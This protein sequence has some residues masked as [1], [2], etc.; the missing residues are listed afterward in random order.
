[1]EP[2]DA[3]GEDGVDGGG[4]LLWIDGDDGPGFGALDEEAAGVGG[5]EGFFEVHGG[6]EGVWLPAGEV[7]REGALKDAEET[8]AGGFSGGGGAAVFHGV[9]SAVELKRLG[10][11]LAE[12]E[13]GEAEGFLAWRGG[14]DATDQIAVV[15]PEVEGAA[16]VVCG[17]RVFGV[18]EIKEGL[19]IFKDYGGGVGGKIVL[20]DGGDLCRGLGGRCGLWRHLNCYQPR[21]AVRWVMWARWWREC[22]A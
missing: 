21:A 5:A 15:V 13:G 20:K 7:A 8:G 4:G 14:E 3:K 17:E 22:Q 19:A 11:G 6:A 1:M 2:E 18:L 9:E 12:F 10:F 16:V